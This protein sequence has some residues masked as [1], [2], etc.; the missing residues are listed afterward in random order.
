M[1]EGNNMK[2]TVFKIQTSEK[3]FSFDPSVD[4]LHNVVQTI[5]N[6]KSHYSYGYYNLS[7]Y[8]QN[9]L[10]RN[11]NA[12]AVDSLSVGAKLQGFIKEY[13]YALVNPRSITV[14]LTCLTANVFEKEVILL[15]EPFPE[16]IQL[17]STFDGLVAQGLPLSIMGVVSLENGVSFSFFVDRH[18]SN[19]DLCHELNN[20]YIASNIILADS[21][22]KGTSLKEIYVGDELVLYTLIIDGTI[23]EVHY[24]DTNT[25]LVKSLIRLNRLSYLSDNKTSKF[26]EPYIQLASGT[27]LFSI[28]DPIA[29]IPN[30]ATLVFP[31][32]PSVE[33][34]YYPILRFLRSNGTSH[35]Y[36]PFIYD[37]FNRICNVE[38]VR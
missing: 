32:K 12:S 38:G 30:K 11:F 2:E 25:S 36:E 15:D 6:A 4:S 29:E 20:I 27:K 18:K 35:H 9:K 22:S 13:K 23:L 8:N 37:E 16:N 14:C 34:S 7:I 31:D 10:C 24:V 3:E 33:L 1:K 5:M 26:T 21:P 17:V 28:K 19:F